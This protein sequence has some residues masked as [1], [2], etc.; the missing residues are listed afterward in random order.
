MVVSSAV[1]ASA[2]EPGVAPAALIPGWHMR[3]AASSLCLVAR[4]GP[5]ERTV[6]QSG[7][8]EFT[9]Q[10]W[11]FEYPFGGATPLQIRNIDRNLCI[12]T[13]GSGESRAVVSTCNAGFRDQLWDWTW[14]STWNG[15][16]FVNLNSN[17]CLVARGTSP[18]VQSVC[19]NYSDQVWQLY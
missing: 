2:G 19:G 9:D 10:G 11:S 8:A 7:C 14:D 3:K 5:G 18:A 1:P 13:R 17:L 6:E 4:S 16:H 12:V 15:Y